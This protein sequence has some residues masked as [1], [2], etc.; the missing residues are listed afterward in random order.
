MRQSASFY[1]T[2]SG[3]SE[4]SCAWHRSASR[5]VPRDLLSLRSCVIRKLEGG[6]GVDSHIKRMG[7]FVVNFEENPQEIPARSCFVGEA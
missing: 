7:M 6:G 1:S 2:R 3:N 5:L 4:L